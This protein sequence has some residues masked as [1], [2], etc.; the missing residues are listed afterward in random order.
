MPRM[1]KYGEMT[2]IMM[3]TVRHVT[4]SSGLRKFQATWFL[5]NRG[6][7]LTFSHWLHVLAEYCHPQ[8]QLLHTCV[9]ITYI[10][11]YNFTPWSRVL[12]KLIIPELLNIF[13]TFCGI[14]RFITVFTRACNFS[15]FLARPVQ[16]TFL[17]YFL[18]HFNIML[19]S[20]PLFSIWSHSIRVFGQ[21]L[22]KPL[23]LP[24]MPHAPRI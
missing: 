9:W 1:H 13:P 21:T 3:A 2:R 22:S 11:S 5:F 12:E 8:T 19:P 14:W 18:I 23:L 24:Y 16:S 4:S 15:L 7:I 17:F 20:M 10:Y 6:Y